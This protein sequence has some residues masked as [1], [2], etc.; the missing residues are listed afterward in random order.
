MTDLALQNNLGKQ[1]KDKITGLEGTI[2]GVTFYLYGSPEYKVLI[3]YPSD[4]PIYNTPVIF[5]VQRVEIL[6]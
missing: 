3:E 4:D 5:D 2:T 1:V 6:K